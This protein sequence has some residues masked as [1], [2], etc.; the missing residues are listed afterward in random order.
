M[1]ETYENMEHLLRKVQYGKYKRHI[2]GNFKVIRILLGLQSGYTKHCC[3]CASGTVVPEPFTTKLR[4]G[5][6]AWILYLEIKMSSISH[7]LIE[8]T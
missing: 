1:K 8:E 6:L 4:S 7:Y 3:F 2:C 5:P